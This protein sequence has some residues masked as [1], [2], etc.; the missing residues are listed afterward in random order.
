MQVNTCDTCKWWIE[1]VAVVDDCEEFIQDR[2]PCG[3]QR[4]GADYTD[5]GFSCACHE[6]REDKKS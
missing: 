4:S 3:N 5:K 2:H 6:R 1:I